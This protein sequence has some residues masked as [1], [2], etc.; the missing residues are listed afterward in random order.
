MR[1]VA[2]LGDPLAEFIVENAKQRR[3]RRPAALHHGH[4]VAPSSRAKQRQRAQTVSCRTVGVPRNPFEAAEVRVA[5]GSG[6][7]HD[8]RRTADSPGAPFGEVIHRRRLC[9]RQVEAC[10]GL[11]RCRAHARPRVVER[12]Q[13]AVVVRGITDLGKRDEPERVGRVT[14]QAIE[15]DHAGIDVADRRPVTGTPAQR[16]VRGREG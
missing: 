10:H 4:Q 7:K 5:E 13:Q 14:L 3:R 11:E 12:T 6:A 1:D 16:R 2:A 8:H 9:R 15:V